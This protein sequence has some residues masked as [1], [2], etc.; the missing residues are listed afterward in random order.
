MAKK[1]TASTTSVTNPT[2]ARRRGK[3]AEPAAA[4]DS[5]RVA[6]PGS[7]SRPSPGEIAEAAYHRYLSRGARHGGDFDDWLEAE[8][9]LRGRRSR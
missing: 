4:N 9:D 8:R 6:A 3:T 7:A 1:N 2:A 5:S